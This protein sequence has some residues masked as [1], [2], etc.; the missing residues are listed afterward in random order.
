MQKQN[1]EQPIKQKTPNNP[2]IVGSSLLLK[3]FSSIKGAENYKYQTV[4]F[5]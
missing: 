2:L 5:I 1:N 4:S 3:Y